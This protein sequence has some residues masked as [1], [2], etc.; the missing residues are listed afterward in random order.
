[1]EGDGR[2][3]KV[4]GEGEESEEEKMEKFFALVRSTR[5]MRDRLKG[6]TSKPESEEKE[7]DK[8]GASWNLTFELEDFVDNKKTE[9]ETAPATA[10]Q[11]AGPSKSKEE[12]EDDKTDK[13]GGLDLELSL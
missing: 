4:Y 12:K 13:D 8:A 10:A 6:G 5:E 1:M 9:S 7:G 2:K 11:S 3:R